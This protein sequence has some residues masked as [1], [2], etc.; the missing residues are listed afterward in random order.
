MFEFLAILLDK[1]EE[2]IKALENSPKVRQLLWGIVV[3]GLLFAVA[4]ILQ[5]IGAIK[6]W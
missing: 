6:W 5:G 2:M 4:S 3:I 1:G